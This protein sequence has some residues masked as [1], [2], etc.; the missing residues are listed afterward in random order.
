MTEKLFYQNQYQ[1]EFEASVTRAVET[2]DGWEVYLDRTQFYPEGGGQPSD[3][4]RI[5]DIPLIDVRKSGDDIAH[6]LPE[7]PKG[8]R[9]RGRVDW[10]WRFDYMQQHT[11]QHILSAV[12]YREFGIGTLAVHLGVE[13]LSIEIDREAVDEAILE[14]VDAQAQELICRNLEVET[15]WTDEHSVGAYK[16]RREPA[17]SGEIRLV[18]I[19]DYDAAAC[20][21]VHCG[22]TGEV[23]LVRRAGS[24]KIRGRLRI[25]WRAGDRALSDYGKKTAL[26]GRLCELY[27][28]KEDELEERSRR[29]LDELEGARKEISALRK[30]RAASAARILTEEAESMES[31]ISFIAV[32]FEGEE[33]NV[34]RSI[35]E[36]LA[37]EGPMLAVLT[38][39]LPEGV[40]WLVHAAV[41]LDF[42]FSAHSKELLAPIGGKGGG[43]PPTW[44]GIGR[45]ISGIQA[46]IDRCRSLVETISLKEQR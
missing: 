19:A 4:G 32:R 39:E 18:N 6:I 30:E 13:L 7:L 2:R 16:L 42:P 11:A 24:E 31:G 20:G 3:R 43:K 26:V 38:N 35:A 12:L 46:F 33:K 15:I 29:L 5:D 21:G 8:S 44:Q 22:R 10:S 37:P 27:S 1:N 34:L 45:E 17:V 23:M 36:A 9:V 40:Q 25:F 28:V 41:G 14:K